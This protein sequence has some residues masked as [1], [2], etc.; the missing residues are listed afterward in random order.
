[1]KNIESWYGTSSGG[2]S[3]NVGFSVVFWLVLTVC[4]VLLKFA[5]WIFHDRDFEFWHEI[6]SYYFMSKIQNHDFSNMQQCDPTKLT[7]L[8]Y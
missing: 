7:R 4:E 5:R 3:M 6:I 8:V 2:I 1:M